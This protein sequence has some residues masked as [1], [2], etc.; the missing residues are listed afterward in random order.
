MHL[1][2]EPA[3][4]TRQFGWFKHC[5]FWARVCAHSVPETCGMKKLCHAGQWSRRWKGLRKAGARPV[6]CREQCF[7]AN[8]CME[9]RV[10]L[11]LPLMLHDPWAVTQIVECIACA[12]HGWLPEVPHNVSAWE[13]AVSDDV[14]SQNVGLSGFPS[15]YSRTGQMAAV[16]CKKLL[17]LRQCPP[18]SPYHTCFF[19]YP[20]LPSPVKSTNNGEL[21]ALEETCTS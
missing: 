16:P 14:L 13:H 4:K 5:S 18:K 15:C 12:V 6:R 19:H 1:L 20:C 17:I 8:R 3:S 11:Q 9:S 21:S 2:I 7:S 10:D